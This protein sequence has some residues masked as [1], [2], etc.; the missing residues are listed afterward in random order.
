MHALLPVYGREVPIHPHPSAKPE[1]GTGAVMICSY[2][3]YTDVLL[4]RELGLTE[5]LAVD[6]DGRLTNVAGPYQGLKTEEG[7]SRIL[8]DL[9]AEGLLEKTEKIQHR[10]PMCSR[11]NTPIEII[12][13]REYYLKQIDFIPKLRQ[14]AKGERKGAKA[15]L[16]F[17]SGPSKHLDYLV[18]EN[19]ILAKTEQ[20]VP[21]IDTSWQKVFELD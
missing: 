13:M 16:V 17:V 9:A 5:V 4:F 6:A 19:V 3:D 12:P 21:E 2:G 1:F 14:L 8:H 15:D 10:T 11:S 18:V 7:R 20:P